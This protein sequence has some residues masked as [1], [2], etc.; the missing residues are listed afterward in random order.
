[1]MLQS[2]LKESQKGLDLLQAKNEELLKII[3]SQKEENKHLAKSIQEKEEKLLENKQHYDIHSTKLKI[4]AC[5]QFGYSL[6]NVLKVKRNNYVSSC[7]HFRSGRG[8][9]NCEEPSV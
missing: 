6:F 8:I 1:M 5:F 2:Q 4:G 7:W 3:E 9:R